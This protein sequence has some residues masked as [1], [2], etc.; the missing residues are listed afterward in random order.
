MVGVAL[1]NRN[2]SITGQSMA[3]VF[4]KALLVFWPFFRSVIF[5]DRPVLEVMRANL[6]FTVLFVMLVAVSSMLYV[7][8]GRLS[9]SKRTILRTEAALHA[10]D[11]DN[12]RLQLRLI[13]VKELRQACE[14]DY[15]KTR[16]IDLL[17][18]GY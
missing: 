18:R 15:D 6:Q 14:S 16:I 12:D 4:L 17:N 10:K 9:E 7:T 5:K 11:V 1:L 2:N 8:A 3:R 13:D